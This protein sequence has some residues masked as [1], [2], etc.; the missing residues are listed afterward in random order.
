MHNHALGGFVLGIL[1]SSKAYYKAEQAG[2]DESIRTFLPNHFKC[3]FA[4]IMDHSSNFV[5]AKISTFF[6][7]VA[8]RKFKT[9][10]RI[11]LC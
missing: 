9:N 3:L 1:N 5:L 11:F 8:H 7:I 2:V 10:L 6:T 4:M